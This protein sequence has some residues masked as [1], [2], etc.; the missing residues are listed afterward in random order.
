MGS[1]HRRSFRIG[2]GHPP[3]AFVE[4]NPL[5]LRMSFIGIASHHHAIFQLELATRKDP[6]PDSDLLAELARFIERITAIARSL[7][8]GQPCQPPGSGRAPTA[9][10]PT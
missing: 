6:M 7:N 10:T 5:R 8:T 4:S 1:E 9:G 3:F 2:L